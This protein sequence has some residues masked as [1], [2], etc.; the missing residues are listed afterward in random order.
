MDANDEIPF[1]GMS[2][3]GVLGVVVIA[4]LVKKVF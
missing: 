1:L 4:L 3:Y 2:L